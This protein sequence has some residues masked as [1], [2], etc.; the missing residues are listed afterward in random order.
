M[1]APTIAPAVGPIQSTNSNIREDV[2]PRYRGIALIL[3]RPSPA[4]S[5]QPSTGPCTGLSTR[6][7]AKFWL[8]GPQS[9]GFESESFF[10]EGRISEYSKAELHEADV[11]PAPG[12]REAVA[13]N[14]R[15]R[16]SPS[17]THRA[18]RARE[19]SQSLGTQ[20]EEVS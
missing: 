16:G 9:R 7:P 5:S 18:A 10:L 19:L 11:L 4:L 2:V 20:A 15:G 8:W 3:G 17:L 12:P 6:A 14:R 13:K 1:P